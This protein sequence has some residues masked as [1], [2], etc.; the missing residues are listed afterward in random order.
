MDKAA[1]M[2]RFRNIF[3]FMLVTGLR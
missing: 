3:I 2:L 1:T